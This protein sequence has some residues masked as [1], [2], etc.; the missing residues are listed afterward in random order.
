MELNSLV[1][2]YL[3]NQGYIETL[4]QFD[5]EVNEKVTKNQNKSIQK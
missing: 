5:A 1:K 3:K 4:M 2:D